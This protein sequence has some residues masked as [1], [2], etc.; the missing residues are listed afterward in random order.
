M[1]IEISPRKDKRFVASMVLKDGKR[2]K[3]HFGSKTGETF[4]DHGDKRLRQNYIARHGA[5]NEDWARPDSA[6][7][8]SRFILWEH[9][10]VDTAVQKFKRRF[11]KDLALQKRVSFEKAF[12]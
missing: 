4:I 9:P 10:D 7:A 11:R 8:L 5:L 2:V 3:I 6:G 1:K 12:L